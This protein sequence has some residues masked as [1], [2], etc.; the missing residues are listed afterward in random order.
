MDES[1]PEGTG[2]GINERKRSHATPSSNIP[3][4]KRSKV[5]SGGPSNVLSL[6]KAAEEEGEEAWSEATP[7]P[8]PSLNEERHRTATAAVSNAPRMGGHASR[9][10]T[11]PIV[12]DEAEME[13]KVCVL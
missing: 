3:S 9:G 7:P 13:R 5:A 2:L 8:I 12:I 4:L 11:P 6:Y 1:A 10:H